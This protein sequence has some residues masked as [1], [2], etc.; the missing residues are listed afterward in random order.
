MGNFTSTL[1]TSGESLTE[2]VVDH[3]ASIIATGG[4][5]YTPSEYLYGQNANVLT[6]F[7]LDAAMAADD[8]RLAKA[9]SVAFIQCV[10]SRT[11]ERPYC[12]RLCCTHTVKSALS[13]K[14]RN[15]EMDIYVLYRDVRTYGFREELYKKAREKGII[16]M[17]YNLE[18]NM[19]DVKAADGQLR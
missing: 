3:G 15:P 9:E 18:D 14:E 13:L 4:K 10:G 11:P 1:R 2:T 5:E 8:P 16:F 19:P 6:H 17:R 7:D 12:S